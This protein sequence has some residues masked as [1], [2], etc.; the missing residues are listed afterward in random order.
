MFGI[1]STQNSDLVDSGSRAVFE[2]SRKWYQ[3]MI[4]VFCLKY[5]AT[6]FWIANSQWQPKN[7]NHLHFANLLTVC[8]FR[9][10]FAESAYSCRFRN[11]SI[12]LY[13]CLIFWS[14]FE[15]YSVLG[16]CLWNQKQQTRSKKSS[17]VPDSATNMILACCKIRLQC[18][19]ITVWP[20]NEKSLLSQNIF[21]S[22]S[23]HIW[24]L[25]K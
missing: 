22:Y 5:D 20:R 10:Q 9:L 16:I 4:A 11:S 14:D 17:T 13:V 12:Y 19:D 2:M 15:R 8:G 7:G 23:F 1:S 25:H 6:S 3:I 24:K 18:T 21:Y